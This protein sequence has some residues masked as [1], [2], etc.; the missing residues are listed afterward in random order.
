MTEQA[1]RIEVR[2]DRG[3]AE[4][5][6]RRTVH[7]GGPRVDQAVFFVD[8]PAGAV[9]T[10]LRTLGVLDGQPHW[11]DGELMEAEAA[12]AKYRELTGIG[13]A[14]PKDPA[15]L[16]WRSQELLELQVFPVAP[17]QPK[18]VEYTLKV[19][20]SYEEGRDRLEL[21]RIGTDKLAAELVVRAARPGDSIEVGGKAVRDGT[22]LRVGRDGKLELSLIRR[23]PPKIDGALASVAFGAGRNLVRWRLEA[24]ARLSVVPRRAHIVVILDASRSVTDEQGAAEIAAARAYLRHFPDAKVRVMTFDRQVHST[25]AG[26]VDVNRAITDLSRLRIVRRNGSRLDDALASAAAAFAELPQGTPRRILALTDLRTRSAL[27]PDKL[28]LLTKGAVLHVATVEPGSPSLARDDEGPWAKPARRT[29]GLLWNAAASGEASDANEMTRVYEEW[30][31][32][33][34]IDHVQLAAAGLDAADVSV[35]E[36]LDE[37]QSIEDLRITKSRVASVELTG[38]LWARPMKKRLTPDEREGKLWSAAVFGTGLLGTLSEKEMMVLARKGRAVSPV[39]SFLAI[40]PGVRPSTEGLDWRGTGEGGGGTGSG[41]GLGSIG[42][43]GRGTGPTFDHAGFL[44][45]ALR[46][47]W[48]ACKG[49][50]GTA[51]L[52]IETTLD[53]IVDLPTIDVQ[54]EG[55]ASSMVACL[56]EAAWNVL[57][58]PSFNSARASFT[59]EL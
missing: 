47:A 38:E 49:K 54:G 40:E 12:A 59:V 55:K 11:F 42:T 21:P 46:P 17:G 19:P 28:S 56:A 33:L 29:G 58:P 51:K 14:Y 44:R 45:Q 2:V 22:S 30:A 23:A 8:L 10:R 53:E 41:I 3:H 48:R 18:T 50:D 15:L 34:R 9:A 5:V 16:S 52:V 20:T 35:P 31:R 6:V 57:L 25:H 13:G 1:H 4:L 32:P 39:T 37:G 24:A 43:I 36:T 27:D 7:N 26:F